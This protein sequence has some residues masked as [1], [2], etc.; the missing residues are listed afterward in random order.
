M[1]PHWMKRQFFWPILLLLCRC[2][3]ENPL[4]FRLGADYCPL[5]E[6]NQWIYQLSFGETSAVK[7]RGKE[8][9][10]GKEA[11]IIEE[12]AETYYWRKDGASLEEYT[13]IKVYLNGEEI[14]LGGKWRPHLELPLV[15]GNKWDDLFEQTTYVW[16]ETVHFRLVKKCEVVGIES[17]KVPKGTFENCYK[18]KIYEETSLSSP[19]FLTQTFDSTKSYEWYAPRVGLVKKEEKGVI[20]E[21]TDAL[22][23]Y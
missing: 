22:I 18:V 12:G 5:E 13:T 4:Y 15:L 9:K 20:Y 14:T 8:M 6:G 16:G 19:L 21:L 7:V 10:G 3:G 1:N 11:Y 23:K 2:A 17:L